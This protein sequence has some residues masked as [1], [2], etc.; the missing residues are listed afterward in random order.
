MSDSKSV[1]K[2][3][4]IL[5]GGEG[6][7]MGAY[8]PL[9][10]FRGRPLVQYPFEVLDSFCDEVIV[11]HGAALDARLVLALADKPKFVKD[12]GSGPLAGLAA[13]AEAAAGEWLFV[14]PCD[15]PFLAV[16]LYDELFAAVGGRH[17]AC[18]S[19][20]G[21]PNPLVAVLRREEAL[22]ASREALSEGLRGVR[23]AFTKID[24]ALVPGS[25]LD[26]LDLDSPE[27]K[28]AAEEGPES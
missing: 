26:L 24:V 23:D 21:V 8:K 2:S 17:G 19:V 15:S 1:D 12:D 22:F 6:K 5:A 25:R 16:P 18:F 27:D 7:R 11:A 4:I 28:W 20:D 10:P 3:G 9:V 14:A 13:A